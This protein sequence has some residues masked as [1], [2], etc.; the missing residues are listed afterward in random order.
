MCFMVHSDGSGVWATCPEDAEQHHVGHSTHMQRK[1]SE[2]AVKHLPRV[3]AFVD[4]SLHASVESASS[5]RKLLYHSFNSAPA[6]SDMNKAPSASPLELNLEFMTAGQLLTYTWSPH[7]P[8]LLLPWYPSCALCN[9][10]ALL[11]QQANKLLGDYALNLRAIRWNEDDLWTSWLGNN[12]ML[13]LVNSSFRLPEPP[14][15]FVMNGIT[16][17]SMGAGTTPSTD[18]PPSSEYAQPFN[19]SVPASCYRF[20]ESEETSPDSATALDRHCI[21]DMA[22]SMSRAVTVRLPVLCHSSSCE[23][24]QRCSVSP[25]SDSATS[26]SDTVISGCT[27]DDAQ[28]QGSSHRLR[29]KLALDGSFAF[30]LDNF[31][32]GNYE[33]VKILFDDGGSDAASDTFRLF[34]LLLQEE[35]SPLEFAIMGDPEL[36]SRFNAP[37][38]SLIFASFPY[39]DPPRIITSSSWTLQQLFSLLSQ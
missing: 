6:N 18:P 24:L 20:L 29:S 10:T 28:M 26:N 4:D 30:A 5:I 7:K 33:R 37:S 31:L 35:L 2:A 19:I 27:G 36:V 3:R 32:G 13:F 34:A 21:V 15:T 23:F 1:L 22:A 25:N 39:M 17:Y 16:W 9:A 8:L 11:A 14:I 12:S 38:S